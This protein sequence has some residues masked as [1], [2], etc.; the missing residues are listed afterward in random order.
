MSKEKRLYKRVLL[1]LSGEALAIPGGD[2]IIAHERL[3][4]YAREIAEVARDDR[5]IQ[6]AVV[7]GGGNIFRGNNAKTLGI[8]PVAADYMGM[9]ATI[10]NCIALQN[11]LENLEVDTRVMSALTVERACEPWIQ[12]RAVMHLERKR[13]VILAAGSGNPGY[14]TDSAATLRGF[15]IGAD[16]VLKATDAEGVYD[17]D[18]RRFRDTARLYKR[19]SFAEVH[20]QRLEVMDSTAFTYSSEKNIPVR[21]F[22]LGEAGNIVRALRGEDLGTLVSSDPTIVWAD[23]ANER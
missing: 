12:R 8:G 1:K 19:I 9:L 18:P 4:R 7:L 13:L 11:A 21:V 15:E 5:G 16:I 23:E 10:I 6:I 22:S 20:A 3:Y 2:E 14:S 17:K